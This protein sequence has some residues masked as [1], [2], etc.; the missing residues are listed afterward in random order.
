M[1]GKTTEIREEIPELDLSAKFHTGF[2]GNSKQAAGVAAVLD[3]KSLTFTR[4]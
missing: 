3:P 2:A 4:S 1:L